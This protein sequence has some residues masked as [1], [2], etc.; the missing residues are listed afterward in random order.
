MCSIQGEGSEVSVR[1]SVIQGCNNEILVRFARTDCAVWSRPTASVF[2]AGQSVR[3]LHVESLHTAE[4]TADVC[5]QFCLQPVVDR[6]T[7]RRQKTE[8]GCL[9]V[10]AS[11][12]TGVTERSEAALTTH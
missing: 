6:S 11:K 10:D 8:R 1:I 5:C 9:W 2:E 12:S 7:N 4:W 3:D